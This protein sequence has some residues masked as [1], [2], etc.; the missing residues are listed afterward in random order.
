MK[1]DMELIRRI[2]LAC[3]ALD[4]G[5]QLRELEGVAVNVLATHILWMHQA[6]L[7]QARI[8]TDERNAVTSAT[9]I[10]LTWDGCEFLDAARNETLWHKATQTVLAPT[11]SFTFGILKDWLTKE[12]GKGLPTLGS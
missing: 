9:A 8:Y 4:N 7:V 10:R 2:A 3:E 12:I 1:R 6:G 5:Q 11:A